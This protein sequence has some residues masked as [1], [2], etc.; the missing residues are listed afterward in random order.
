MEREGKIHK[1]S[2]TISA[3]K[4]L[5]STKELHGTNYTPFVL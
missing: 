1:L 2:M 4:K 3:I 5:V